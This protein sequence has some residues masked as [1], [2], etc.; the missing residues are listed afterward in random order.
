MVV[1]SVYVNCAEA[2]KEI[3]VQMR[4]KILA[5]KIIFFDNNDSDEQAV[6]FPTRFFK[7]NPAR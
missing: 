7:I 1:S 4:V 5:I 3:S 6:I 2:T